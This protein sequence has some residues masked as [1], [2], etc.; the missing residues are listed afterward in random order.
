MDCSSSV[1]TVTNK[2]EIETPIP[3]T[4]Y[5]RCFPHVLDIAAFGTVAWESVPGG[6][7]ESMLATDRYGMEEVTCILL[8]EVNHAYER[9]AA[10]NGTNISGLCSSR[11]YI[12]ATGNCSLYKPLIFSLF[13][14]FSG[15]PFSSSARKDERGFNV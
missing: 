9:K 11:R 4:R 6:R 15:A 8:V 2:E 7:Q 10:Q 12:H 13:R 14:L 1:C 3:Y 5:N